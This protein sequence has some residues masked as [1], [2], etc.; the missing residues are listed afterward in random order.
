MLRPRVFHFVA[1]LVALGS[2]TLFGQ[3]AREAIELGKGATALVELEGGKKSAS[4]TCI[5]ESGVFVTNKHVVTNLGKD[6]TLTLT[7]RPNE[8]R[9]Q[10]IT[11]KVMRVDSTWDLAVLKATG[12]TEKFVYLAL[13]D[14]NEL[15]E[16]MTITAFGFPFGS[17]LAANEGSLP[18]ISINVGRITALRKRDGKLHQ[19]QFDAQVN[20]GNSGGPLIDEKGNVVGIVST[21]VFATGVNFAVPV[22]AVKQLISRP[23]ISFQPPR[24][25]AATIYDA[26]K[27]R[28]E[29]APFLE[30]PTDVS[31]NLELVESNGATRQV[32]L[33]MAEKN[34]YEATAAP[35]IKPEKMPGPRAAV[36][37]T[38]PNG[39]ITGEVE[40]RQI[41]VAGQALS[42]RDLRSIAPGEKWKVTRQ[43]GTL[44]EGAATGLSTLDLD[45]GGYIVKLDARR[46][47]DIRLQPLRQATPGVSYTLLVQSGDTELYRAT[48]QLLLG[49][50]A[51]ASV[52]TA[53]FKSY[54]GEKQ[55]LEIP[56]L[57]DDVILAK[58]GQL[59]LLYLKK[60]RKIAVYDVNQAKIARYLSLGSDDVFIAAGME[61]LVIVEPGNN[62]VERWS[63]ETFER[64]TTRTLTSG[65]VKAIALGY[66][67]AGPLL[68]HQ[69]VGTEALAGASYV[70]YDLQSLQPIST[71]RI[72]SHNNSYRDVVHIRASGT[73]DVFGLWATSHSPQGMESF[74]LRGT[75]VK[76][77]YQHDS[78]GH[79]VPNYDGTAIA[80]GIAGVCTTEL[81]RKNPRGS[82]SLPAVPSLHPRFYV[83]IPTEPGAQ[84]NLGS[85]PFKGLLPAVRLI[86]SEQD[87]IQ[88]PSLD[89][90]ALDVGGGTSWARHDFTLDKRVF[91]IPQANQLVTIPYTNDKLVIQRFNLQESLREKNIDYLFVS[92]TPPLWFEKGQ[93]FRYQIQVESSKPGIQLELASGPE[94]MQV[95]EAGEVTWNVPP[96]YEGS[97]VSIIVMVLGADGQRTNHTFRVRSKDAV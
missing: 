49:N 22:S 60:T 17:A 48:G 90:G 7:L 67:S 93:A 96:D 74:V 34:I 45:L 94:G 46:A 6:E 85:E 37:V 3:T 63:L 72:Q 43:D 87:L 21:G 29:V 73:G 54:A 13:G 24:V 78:A 55:V 41:Q 75:K 38:F 1:T 81:N 4:A 57:V 18:N 89:L 86:D 69:A 12:S 51:T 11:A 33:K 23:E 59:I 42:L 50:V 31:V 58:G 71:E 65:V 14:D 19:I 79:I 66:A 84:I 44:L 47:K 82:R 77:S 97:D 30:E 68:V 35:L 91:Y 8:E 26:A 56:D 40:D 27:F 5:H 10:R 20:P 16:T 53:V 9:Q 76:T 83:V 32:A 36:E 70:L 28:V 62:L 80:T 61:K 92:S 39:S 25:T 2:S 88:L 52:T 64:E 95:S 15:F